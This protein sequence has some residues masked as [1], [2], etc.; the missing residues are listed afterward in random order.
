MK[1]EEIIKKQIDFTGDD[2]IESLINLYTDDNIRKLEVTNSMDFHISQIK[3]LVGVI[4]TLYSK[5][6]TLEYLKEIDKK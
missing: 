4:K 2:D 5:L 6:T 1:V 3:A